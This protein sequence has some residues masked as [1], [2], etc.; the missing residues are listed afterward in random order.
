[1]VNGGRPLGS[2]PT[3]LTPWSPRSRTTDQHHG[4]DHRDQHGRHLG[5]DA[6]QD[7]HDGDAEQPDGGCRRHHLPVGEALHEGLGLGR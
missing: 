4:G 5:Q 1:M 3:R 2:T 7:H 6:A